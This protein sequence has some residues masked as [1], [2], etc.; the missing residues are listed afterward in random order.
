MPLVVSSKATEIHNDRM[1]HKNFLR[2]DDQTIRF[3][4]QDEFFGKDGCSA[5]V[6]GKNIV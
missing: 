4:P 2:F 3:V 6:Y 1:K 5:G